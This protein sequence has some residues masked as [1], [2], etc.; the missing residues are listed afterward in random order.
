MASSG[1]ESLQSEQPP[2]RLFE[3]YR[4]NLQRLQAHLKN[5]KP[6]GVGHTEV[7][8][9]PDKG[10]GLR[11]TRAIAEGKVIAH[12]THSKP[13][14]CDEEHLYGPKNDYRLQIG[15][16]LFLPRPSEHQLAGLANDALSDEGNNAQWRL[17][18]GVPSLVSSTNIEPGTE[19]CVAY[20]WGYW[21]GKLVRDPSSIS[22]ALREK[23]VNYYPQCHSSVVRD[24]LYHMENPQAT[25][26]AALTQPCFHPPAEP[27]G[28][29]IPD[30]IDQLVEYGKVYLAALAHTSAYRPAA[31]PASIPSKVPPLLVW[32]QFGSTRVRALVDT[33]ACENCISSALAQRLGID[34]ESVPCVREVP[35]RN[36]DHSLC[37]DQGR[38]V[39]RPVEIALQDNL[40]GW[41]PLRL[42]SITI[43]SSLVC[44][45]ILALPFCVQ[46]S[47][48]I[49]ASTRRMYSKE[50]QCTFDTI[51]ALGQPTASDVALI[52]AL[53]V[54]DQNGLVTT[55]RDTYIASN[56]MALIPVCAHD[57]ESGGIFVFSPFRDM[58]ISASQGVYDGRKFNILVTNDGPGIVIPAGTPIGHTELLYPRLTPIIITPPVAPAPAPPESV[59]P[60]GDFIAN[61]T[62]ATT[63]ATDEVV[64]PP[65]DDSIPEAVRE[66]YRDVLKQ[67]TEVFRNDFSE[68]PWD[69]PPFQIELKPDS[70]PAR[71]RHYR[72]SDDHKEKLRV[73]LAKYL[74]EKVVEES[75][76]PWAS[77]AFFVPK[78]DGGLRFVI[79]YRHLNNVTKDVRWPLPLIEDVLDELRGSCVFSKFDAH[80]GFFQMPIDRESREL[81][82]FITPLGLYQFTRLPMGVRN[83][84]ALFSRAMGSMVRDLSNIAIYLDDTNVHSGKEAPDE[85]PV[86]TYKRHLQY[87]IAFLRRCEERHLKLNGKK[88]KIG[89][90]ETKFLG[91]IVSGEGVTADLAKVD[92]VLGFLPPTNV[93][94]LMVFLGIV[95]YY[96]TWIRNCSARS[97]HLTRLLHKD[98]KFVWD[99][100]C[101]REFEDLR[102]V[103]TKE[104]VVRH[105]PDPDREF[106]VFTDASD[107]A[108]GSVLAQVD[109]QGREQV[110]AY[111]SRML[112]QAEQRYATFEKECLAIVDAFNKFKVYLSSKPFKVYTDHHSLKTLLRWK[113]PKP[114]IQR[115]IEVLSSYSYTAYYR[116]GCANLN[117][118]ALSRMFAKHIPP[119]YAVGSLKVTA[120]LS[121]NPKP[122]ELQDMEDDDSFLELCIR[123][124]V[125]VP[126][127]TKEVVTGNMLAP[128]AEDIVDVRQIYES[129]REE[130][131]EDDPDLYCDFEDYIGKLVVDP[132]SKEA[133][134]I[135]DV[136]FDPLEAIYNVILN[137]LEPAKANPDADVVVPLDT[138]DLWIEQQQLRVP[139]DPFH[140]F[141]RLFRQRVEV[142]IERLVARSKLR[143]E[144]VVLLQTAGSEPMYYRVRVDKQHRVPYYQLLIP[145]EDEILIQNLIQVAHRA[146][147]HAAQERTLAFL[148][149]RVFFEGMRKKVEAYCAQCKECQER[150]HT[151]STNA[152][153]YQIQ[154]KPPLTGPHQLLSIDILGPLK[155]SVH[156]NSYALFAIDHFSKWVYGKALPVNNAMQVAEFLINEIYF[157]V[158][159]PKVVMSDGGPEFN[160]KLNQELSKLLKVKWSVTTPYH[161]QANGQVE[162][163]NRTFAEM[164]SKHLPE[165]E[166]HHWDEYLQQCIHAY[167]ISVNTATQFTPFELHHG[168]TCRHWVD[169][170]LPER[171]PSDLLAAKYDEYCDYYI[172]IWKKLEFF[173]RQCADR[174]DRKH[175]MYCVPKTVHDLKYG[176]RTLQFDVGDLVWVHRPHIGQKHQAHSIVKFTRYWRGPYTVSRKISDVVYEVRK[177][178]RGAPEKQHISH[179]KPYLENPVQ[180]FLFDI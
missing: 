55:R 152:N 78:P 57:N 160:N 34:V 12:L 99:D 72:F 106:I 64:L 174:L 122:P 93:N 136:G 91:H 9:S 28:T 114:R 37:Q 153:P 75:T 132:E 129:L 7:F 117:A 173:Y 180:E 76:S 107:Y 104:P 88:C 126:P 59:H 172:K 113:N 151:T 111:Q 18:D 71:F 105:Y 6:R 175:S 73:L 134:Y 48:V 143:R 77:P 60:H 89:C 85:D 116:A 145:V 27:L 163:F 32:V 5:T 53:R 11:C 165:G 47:L 162:R 176:F 1:T 102:E 14:P 125:M 168:S 2:F 25:V 123:P 23:I 142:E 82:A 119:S 13:V 157:K 50:L 20:G 179:L 24:N 33:G 92:K 120:D 84:P 131:P 127:A 94:L 16:L 80:S 133:W 46:H 90:K 41:R 26:I 39:T 121:D 155:K 146:V 148:E 29:P 154:E 108:I 101:Q 69:T 44:D 35:V 109:D 45:L 19:I 128:I 74:A 110:I 42:D 118:D 8:Q 65:L 137:P 167:N 95:N 70:T 96:R 166:H 66:E 3:R 36:A 87:I 130:E 150:G 49:D 40:G 10:F 100:A 178:G 21:A 124:K 115:W 22:P 171:L 15:D 177:R 144:H 138:V 4:D 62:P 54:T 140:G 164:I 17:V 30:N 159:C 161:P 79:D 61:I 141:D 81:T 38:L 63:A 156:G 139:G 31:A 169:R 149:T 58:P 67:F 56:T 83:G 103:L 43:M 158:G 98:T 170:T 97:I 112:T 135:Q 51:Q 86:V 68:C 52:S 147:G